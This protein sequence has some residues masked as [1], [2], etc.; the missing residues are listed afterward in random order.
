MRIVVSACLLCLVFAASAA[1]EDGQNPVERGRAIAQ[2]FCSPCH[3]I[4]KADES[5]R[6]GAPPFRTLS[7]TLDLGELPSRLRRG[8]TSGHPAMP[9][10]KFNGRDARAMRDY[11]RTIQD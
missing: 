8:L 6:Q 2:E 5:P 11:L 1:A 4:G 3:A 7:K 10:F 9:S